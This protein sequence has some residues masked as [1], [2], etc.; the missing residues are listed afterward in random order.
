MKQDLLLKPEFPRTRAKLERA[1]K[2]ACYVAAAVYWLHEAFV[3]KPSSPR[4]H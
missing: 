2:I 4:R 3:P 1:V